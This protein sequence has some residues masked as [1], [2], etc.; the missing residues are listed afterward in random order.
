MHMLTTTTLL[1]RSDASHSASQLFAGISPPEVHIHCDFVP[2]TTDQ[3]P[4]TSP[5]TSGPPLVSAL[6]PDEEM[7]AADKQAFEDWLIARWSKKDAMIARYYRDGDLVHGEKHARSQNRRSNSDVFLQLSLTPPSA[8][9]EAKRF[10]LIP[11][12]C[13]L[14]YGYYRLGRFLFCSLRT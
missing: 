11:F 12:A 5:L 13:L 6:Q 1:V 2:L 8:L 9:H 7:N 14:A 4:L 3:Q 10:L